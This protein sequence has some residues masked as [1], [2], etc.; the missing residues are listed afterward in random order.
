MQKSTHPVVHVRVGPTNRSPKVLYD[1][2]RR[3]VDLLGR[4]GMIAKRG[5]TDG[6]IRSRG[7]MRLPF[8][9]K[10]TA[11]KYIRRVERLGENAI[12]C[13]LKRAR[14]RYRR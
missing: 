1:T 14:E 5:E 10:A 9:D 2:A 3:Q 12:E 13:R 11:R 6:T 8:P 7:Y 4:P